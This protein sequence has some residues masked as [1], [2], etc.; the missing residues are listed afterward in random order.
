ME[1]VVAQDFVHPHEVRMTVL[2]HTGIGRDGNLAVGEGVER[3]DG[4]V[5]RDVVLQLD[6]DLHA[7]RRHVVH[8][9]DLDLSLVAFADD[10]VDQAFGGLSEGDLADGQRAFVHLL[11]PGADL[12]LAAA[13]AVVVFG[14]V[15]QAARREIRIEFEGLLTERRHTGVQQFVEVVRQDLDRKAHRDTVGALREQQR[16]LHRQHHRLLVGAVVR[17]DVLGN[18]LV[19]GHL[20]RELAQAR[21]DIAGRSGRVT[22]IDIAPVTLAVDEIVFLAQAHERILD[23]GVAVR[24]VLHGVAHDAGHLVVAAVVGLL[25]GVEDAALHRLEAVLDMRNG[26]VQDHVRGVI[27]EPVLVHAGEFVP[28]LPFGYQFLVLL[29]RSVAGTLFVIDGFVGELFFVLFRSRVQLL[30]QR[31]VHCVVIVFF[32][33]LTPGLIC[34]SQGYI[35]TSSVCGRLPASSVPP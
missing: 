2:D 16:E 22:G 13:Q 14:A 4:L 8:L 9:L 12:D 5:G 30:V 33:H 35:R 28:V 15:H 18:F 21:L 17:G 3:V 25:H 26:T 32:A 31:G 1:R 24:M 27:Q 23:G 6:H 34:V 7:V 11:D 10:G 20:Q 29:G 19:E